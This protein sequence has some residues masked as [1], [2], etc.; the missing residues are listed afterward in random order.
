MVVVVLGDR[1][2]L[3]H[4]AGMIRFHSFLDLGDGSV[5]EGGEGA[6][7]GT[8][9]VAGQ[10]GS[11]LGDGVGIAELEAVTDGTDAVL[12]LLGSLQV[13]GQEV[14]IDRDHDLGID[15]GHSGDAAGTA[16]QIPPSPRYRGK[17]IRK[18][19][20]STN[21]RKKVITPEIYPFP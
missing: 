3:L 13:A 5:T 21:E 9:G 17:R 6:A 18:K 7:A 4:A 20:N 14:M 1:G 19:S 16:S 15:V 12:G 10:P 2:K 8:D 11:R